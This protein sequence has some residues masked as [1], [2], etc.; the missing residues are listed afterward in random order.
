MSTKE[1]EAAEVF[2]AATGGRLRRTEAFL[3]LL[4]ML[5]FDRFDPLKQAASRI[6]NLKTFL[7]L[8][9]L[10]FKITPT[11]ITGGSSLIV[12]ACCFET[13]SVRYCHA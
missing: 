8:K 6:G 12:G 10:G 11:V 7:N 13:G 2:S 3:K 4:Q 1:D 9:G 5:R